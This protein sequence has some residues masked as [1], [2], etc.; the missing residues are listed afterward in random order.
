M[1]RSSWSRFRIDLEKF[2][3]NGSGAVL[4][5][6]GL[7]QTWVCKTGPAQNFYSWHSGAQ[8]LRNPELKVL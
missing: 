2:V 4:S 5:F 1:N 6:V 8:R 3:G 7:C